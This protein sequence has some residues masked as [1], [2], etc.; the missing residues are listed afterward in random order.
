MSERV[1]NGKG[2]FLPSEGEPQTS[3]YC[4]RTYFHAVQP[5]IAA[6]DSPGS[7]TF[8]NSICEAQFSALGVRQQYP[9]VLGTEF[10]T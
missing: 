1:M 4:W 5:A 2:A 10:F 9:S 8:N 7:Y 6:L 3:G